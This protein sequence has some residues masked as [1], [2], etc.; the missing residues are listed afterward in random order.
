MPM[1]WETLGTLERGT[2]IGVRTTS[3]ATVILAEGDAYANMVHGLNVGNPGYSYD[4]DSSIELV[5][6]AKGSWGLVALYDETAAPTFALTV[7]VLS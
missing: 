1:K 3:F 7:N 4:V 5:V 2:R 6:P